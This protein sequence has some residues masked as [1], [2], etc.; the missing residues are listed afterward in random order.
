MTK[1]SLFKF[2]VGQQVDMP[3]N[4]LT[5]RVAIASRIPSE[6]VPFYRVHDSSNGW[7]FVPES[8][9]AEVRE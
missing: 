3:T 7:A 4:G 2:T 1:T 9:L 5:R 8:A 6:P